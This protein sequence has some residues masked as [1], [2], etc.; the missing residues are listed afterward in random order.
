MTVSVKVNWITLKI[1][2]ANIW[3]GGW[4][5]NESKPGELVCDCAGGAVATLW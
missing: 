2:L 1:I 4:K 5:N 3:Y